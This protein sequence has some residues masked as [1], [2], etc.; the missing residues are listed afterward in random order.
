M[1]RTIL[2][3]AD[4]VFDLNGLPDASCVGRV[5]SLAQRQTK[6]IGHMVWW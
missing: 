1:K 2:R 3:R 4:V 5:C 6:A